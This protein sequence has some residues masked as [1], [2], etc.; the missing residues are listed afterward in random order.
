MKEIIFIIALFVV[1]GFSYW[2]I[3]RVANTA[4][5]LPVYGEKVQ[6]PDGEREHTVPSFEFTNQ[7]GEVISDQDIPEKIWVVDYIFTSCP[8]ICPQM[9][10]NLV[11]VHDYYRNDDDV[12]L[13]SFTV[14]PKRDKP[15]RMK[16]FADRYGVNHDKWYFLT[17]EKKN[18]YL[19]ARKGFYLSATDGDGSSTDFIHS[20]NVVLVDKD[21][22]IRGIYNG[23]DEASIRQLINDINKLKRE[24][25]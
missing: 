20:E 25:A 9:T 10:R 15:E 8:S 12:Q 23:T 4:I 7:L 19:L 18:L 21:R 11:T 2:A 16:W 24:Q 6:T 5:P 14:D 22:Q 3:D 13:L 17:G 1:T